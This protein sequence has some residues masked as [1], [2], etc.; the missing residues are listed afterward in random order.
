MNG[1][2]QPSPPALTS[3]GV[4]DWT[5]VAEFAVAERPRPF[6]YLSRS[7]NETFQF[8]VPVVQ[9]GERRAEGQPYVASPL[10]RKAPEPMLWQQHV[11]DEAS[12]PSFQ[13][14]GST[15]ARKD[16]GVS[17]DGHTDDYAALQRCVDEH[18]TVVLPKG[19]YKLSRTLVLSRPGGALVGVGRTLSV[20]MVAA[21]G[22][23]GESLL[24]VTG[25]GFSLFQ[26]EYISF[27][28]IADVYLLDWQSPSGVWRQAHGYRTC[29]LFVSDPPPVV[30]P[31]CAGYPAAQREKAV[32]L[33][34]PLSVISG[35][36]RFYS[37]YVEDWHYQGPGYRHLLVNNS[38]AAPSGGLAIYHINPDCGRGDATV[39][40]RNSSQVSVFGMKSEG[41]YCQL[42]VRE[43]SHILYT[44]F[45][46]FASPFGIAQGYPEPY[47]QY[48]PSMIRVERSTNVTLANLWGACRIGCQ[49]PNETCDDAF[50][51]V[52]VSPAE[53]SFVMWQ[54]GLGP[55][56]RSAEH[57]TPVLER[58]VLFKLT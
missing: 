22:F 36:G 32:V 42:W 48:T 43:S 52:G 10:Q 19:F 16:C 31:S 44:G 25:V 29:D 35:G 51:G 41:N 55:G 26:L 6:N 24:K 37:F 33:D 49:K 27:W 57:L 17:G 7:Y 2:P 46:G 58:P 47:A 38:H 8:T 18:E 45:G 53:W 3:L 23:T 12:F 56:P 5:L 20:L 54:N 15:D 4:G 13:S 39:E 1:H 34:R 14:T 9:N 50:G 21:D 30:G 11:W 28:R 40:V